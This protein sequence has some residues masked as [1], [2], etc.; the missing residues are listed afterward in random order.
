MKKNRRQILTGLSATGAG[1]IGLQYYSTP[2]LAAE[3]STANNPNTIE[4]S[5]GALSSL[6]VKETD[7]SLSTFEWSNLG[8]GDHQINVTF[9]A[10]LSDEPSFEQVSTGSFTVDGDSGSGFSSWDSNPFPVNI[11]ANTSISASEFASNTVGSTSTTGVDLKVEFSTGEVSASAETSFDVGVKKISTVS[12]PHS[13]A[14][15]KSYSTILSE[16]DGDGSSG[17]P[18]IITNDHEL[19][20][21]E[22]GKG[23][24]YVLGNDIDASQTDQWS[25]GGFN[26][27]GYDN[28]EEQFHGSLNG[29]GHVIKGITIDSGDQT[30][31]F[32]YVSGYYGPAHIQN[33]GLE[34]FTVT[35]DKFDTGGLIG[36]LEN[37]VLENVYAVNG[38]V[39]GDESNRLG[40]VVG[41]ARNGDEPNTKFEN[42]YAANVT[43]DVPQGGN[44]LV[45]RNNNNSYSLNNL[46][47]AYDGA[48]LS[49]SP[50]TG[51]TTS[52]I[53]GSSASSNMSGFDFTNTWK[54][55]S[56]DY[57]ELR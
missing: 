13:S 17:N 41:L 18:Y 11:I 34:D 52:E 50:G 44:M 55:V 40:G 30:G 57:P 6:K 47:W 48:D 20:A 26:P 35:G 46:Y 5:S 19:Q 9:S 12:T 38:T 21:I 8:S 33:I 32:G 25:N 54:T 45:G 36:V 51:L 15:S 49:S 39:T 7:F 27:V 2:A 28:I 43:L 1:V 16:M 53:Q 4:H 10:K 29:K 42:V 14:P 24:Y 23:A 37:A 3:G 22:G 56:G 31:V